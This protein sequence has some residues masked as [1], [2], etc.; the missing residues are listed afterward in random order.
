MDSIVG[1]VISLLIVQIGISVTR[2]SIDTLMD[3]EAPPELRARVKKT[4]ESV[5]DVKGVN[6]VHTRGSWNYKIVDASI[7]VNRGLTMSDLSTLQERIKEGIFSAIPEVHQVN[8]MVNEYVDIITVAVSSN[9]TGLE[10][11]FANDVGNCGYFVIATV[12]KDTIGVVGS[13][14]NPYKTGSR[15]KGAMIAHFMRD[16]RVDE[17]VTG[18]AG[19]GVVQWLRGYGIGVK[20]VEGSG[21]TVLDAINS[22]KFFFH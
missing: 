15:K 10:A 18:H 5:P 8:V 17:V 7:T 2:T 12:Q 20:L 19:E 14:A 11:A 3:K 16:N 13:F 9:G 4:I 6:Y 1:I 22:A 21:L